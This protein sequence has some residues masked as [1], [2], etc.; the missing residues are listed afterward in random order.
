MAPP[1]PRTN[2]PRPLDEPLRFER[3][4]LTKVWGGRRLEQVPGLA[5]DVEGPVGETWELSDRAE[6]VSRVRGGEHQGRKLHELVR[7]HR[8]E[9]MGAA[10]LTEDDRFPLLVK[11]LSASQPLSVQV[12]PDDATAKRLHAGD[13]GKDEAWYVLDAEPGALVYLGLRS[14]VDASAF[15][16]V[17]GGEGVVDALQPW[18]VRAGDV[19]DVPA[20]TLHAIGAGVTLLEVQQSSDLTYRLYDWGRLGLDG[21]PRA[22]HVEQALLA[23]DYATPIT[24][25]FAPALVSV[26]GGRSARDVVR[27]PA[28]ALSVLEVEG[29]VQAHTEDR[30][31]VYVVVE[32]HVR[33][34]RPGG[35]ASTELA[36]GDTCLVP[37][38]FGAHTLSAGEDPARIIVATTRT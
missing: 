23:I 34:E 31:L 35:A 36:T 13:S 27:R 25:P 26:P 9:L 29:H 11:Y 1:D 22:M 37:A 18:R 21:K 28:F 16:A 24:G 4:C 7:D 5:L 32:G 3:V 38:A 2:A 8:A 30:P 15:A 14:D 19:I 12:H 6:H 17:A 33:I 20:G 10:G